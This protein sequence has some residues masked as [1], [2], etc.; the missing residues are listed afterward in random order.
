M[1]GDR[2]RLVSTVITAALILGAVLLA[3]SSAAG[4]SVTVSP[5][6]SDFVV[7]QTINLSGSVSLG[8]AEFNRLT[9]VDLVIAGPQG[10]TAELPLNTDPYST[11]AIVDQVVSCSPSGSGILTVDVTYSGISVVDGYRYGYGYGDGLLGSGSSASVAFNIDWT[12]PA[13]LDP[14]PLFT[15]LPNSSSLFS[16]PVI[17]V[18]TLAAGLPDELPTLTSG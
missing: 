11:T 3:P 4:I 7:G 10:C 6:A 16:V 8:D 17:P 13:F 14:A 15:L 1:R 12:P 18:P 5:S 2:K 9:S